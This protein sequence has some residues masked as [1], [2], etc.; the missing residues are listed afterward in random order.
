MSWH[1]RLRASVA[2]CSAAAWIRNLLH[3]TTAGPSDEWHQRA[4]DGAPCGQ[5]CDRGVR[6]L[7]GRLGRVEAGQI[8]ALRAK[9]LLWAEWL[10]AANQGRRVG[11]ECVLG[12]QAAGPSSK[13]LSSAAKGANAASSR[14]GCGT[15]KGDAVCRSRAGAACMAVLGRSAS[16]TRCA[17]HREAVGC[18]LRLWSGIRHHRAS[19][20]PPHQPLSEC[21][22]S[23]P[24]ATSQTVNTNTARW[25]SSL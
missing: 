2:S 10:G 20:P 3:C 11:E 9:W 13:H 7:N 23:N 5:R 19:H 21:A 14:R 25:V 17:R 6:L 15:E 1:E 8:A 18:K 22:T 12:V 4:D 16:V 24:N